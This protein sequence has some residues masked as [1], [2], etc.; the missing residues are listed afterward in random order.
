M[1]KYFGVVTSELGS[2]SDNFVVDYFFSNDK[3][4]LEKFCF[5]LVDSINNF[6]ALADYYIYELTE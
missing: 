2:I 3:D 1:Q 6:P 5:E 4:E